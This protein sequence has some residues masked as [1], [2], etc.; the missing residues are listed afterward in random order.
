MTGTRQLIVIRFRLKVPRAKWGAFIFYGPS[1]MLKLTLYIR[2]LISNNEFRIS[3]VEV[4]TS[5]FNI[6]NSVFDINLIN[7]VALRPSAG[8]LW[9]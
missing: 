7:S 2:I 3:N 9:T 4:L 5:K 8:V 6:R 1:A